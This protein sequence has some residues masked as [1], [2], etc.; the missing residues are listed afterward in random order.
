MVPSNYCYR[1]CLEDERGCSPISGLNSIRHDRHILRLFLSRWL[2]VLLWPHSEQLAPSHYALR[3]EDP[4]GDHVQYG[5]PAALEYGV[6]GLRRKSVLE[7]SDP[8]FYQQPLLKPYVFFDVSHGREQRGGIGGGSLRN[9]VSPLQS[10]C[11]HW[12][13][14]IA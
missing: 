5:V 11:M 3:K 12:G 6:L 2:L 1:G 4:L 7:A 14:L 13:S 10:S 9:Q 8:I